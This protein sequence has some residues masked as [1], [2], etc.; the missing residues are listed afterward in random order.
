MSFAEIFNFSA[1]LVETKA[2]TADTIWPKETFERHDAELQAHGKKGKMFY[3]CGTVYPTG[4]FPSRAERLWKNE[5]L[6][7]LMVTKY[8]AKKLR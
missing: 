5:E 2:K 1:F 3:L 4:S 6:T 8:M 7:W